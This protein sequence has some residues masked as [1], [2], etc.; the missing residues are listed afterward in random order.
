MV[1]QSQRLRCMASLKFILDTSKKS[2]P[3]PLKNSLSIV[4]DAFRFSALSRENTKT[5]IEHS[6]SHKKTK[7]T[8]KNR[9]HS[10]RIEE[11]EESGQSWSP[12]SHG[13]SKDTLGRSPNTASHVPKTATTYRSNLFDPN[14]QKFM[15]VWTL[16]VVQSA[17]QILD[18]PNGGKLKR[19]FLTGFWNVQKAR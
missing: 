7:T 2:R 9:S 14:N 19:S 8:T 18:T 13:G 1:D 15:W 4:P 5:G 3:T 10:R 12:E 6:D 16:L 17:I 11:E